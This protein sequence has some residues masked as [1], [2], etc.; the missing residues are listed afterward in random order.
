MHCAPTNRTARRKRL[1]FRNPRAR[2]IL[3]LRKTCGGARAC[4]PKIWPWLT[5]VRGGATFNGI[6]QNGEQRNIMAADTDSSTTEGFR[7]PSTT[8]L[9]SVRLT[10]VSL[11]R[12]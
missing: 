2:K 6:E 1:P 4:V 11:D 10:V 9:G 3:P 8:R 7:I 12:E 5:A